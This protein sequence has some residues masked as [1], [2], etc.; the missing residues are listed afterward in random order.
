M[1]TPNQL[2]LLLEEKYHYE[3]LNFCDLA[4]ITTDPS[5]IYTILQSVYQEHFKSQ[6]RIVFYSS[7]LPNK[8]LLKHLDQA[9]ST[10]DISTFFVVLCCTEDL[11][12]QL[13]EFTDP[14]SFLQVTLSDT[15]PLLDSFYIPETF[16]PIP[17][18]NLEIHHNGNIHPCCV[19]TDAIGTATSESLS[20]VWTGHKLQTLREEF[21]KGNK[22]S[23]CKHCWILEDQG[24]TSNRQW[25]L[26]RYEKKLPYFIKNPVIRSL[27]IKPGNTCNF[28]CRICN[29]RNSSLY[30][31]EYN[32]SF[33]IKVE[34]WR[35]YNE[36]VWEEMG[37]LL[38]NIEQIDFYGGEPMLVKQIFALLESA[39]QRNL[40]ENIKLHFNTNGSI[41][42]AGIIDNL[43]KF[44]GVDIALSID[45]IG[46]RFELERGGNWA[47][48]EENILKFMQLRSDKI[49][50]YIMPTINIQ[51][52]YYVDNLL[53]WA[54]NI[55]IDVVPNFL[56]APEWLNID[57]MTLEARQLV[58]DKYHLSK[59]PLLNKL[60]RRVNE[61]TGSD[62]KKFFQEMKRFDE[63]R[64]EKFS[65]TH[66]EIAH[67]MGYN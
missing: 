16:C 37:T 33:N 13:S 54:E 45:N 50:A 61:S 25:Y 53:D 26:S 17:W 58:F 11:S 43:L 62:G 46:K 7:H 1:L 35:D 3:I 10:V 19:Y 44:Q 30:A 64:N 57:Y 5:D 56:D 21:L 23:G 32:R 65:E 8:N 48:V 60:A 66:S 9:L 15:K 40:A 28:K 2:K 42:P 49:R 12:I 22:P 36:Y 4:D 41:Y 38:E 29:P 20:D 59:N 63:L 34:K 67:A 18:A 39:V 55:G 31:E 52:I 51:N 24:L 6:Q 27:D 14:I 47:E